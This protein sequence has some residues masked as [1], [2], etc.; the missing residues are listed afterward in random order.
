V[1]IDERTTPVFWFTSFLSED[2]KN[3]ESFLKQH[4]IQSRKFF[5]PLHLQPCYQDKK[6]I[7][8]IS[9]DFKISEHVY[10]T[11]ISLPSSY[12]LTLSDQ[13]TV[14]KSIREYY[15]NRD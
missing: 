2:A 14:I 11:G 6:F 15:D 8:N 1:Y 10:N 13:N 4:G 5:Y 7:K 12:T 3:L 9:D